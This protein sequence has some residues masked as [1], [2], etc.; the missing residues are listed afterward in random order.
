M[1]DSTTC[2]KTYDLCR[3]AKAE[4][5]QQMRPVRLYSCRADRQDVSDLLA[6]FS[7]SHKLQ[8]LTLAFGQRVVAIR[9]AAFGEAPDVIVEHNLRDGRTEE[10][11]PGGNGGNRRNQLGAGGKDELFRASPAVGD[12]RIYLRS[13]Q[14]LYCVK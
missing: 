11:L 12:G 14:M 6:A 2:G 4:R 1:H 3:V 13:D 7:F 9:D 10:R 8:H 5:L